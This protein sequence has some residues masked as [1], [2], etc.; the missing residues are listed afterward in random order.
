MVVG[1]S[2]T[3]GFEGRQRR[4]WRTMK[5]SRAS[6]PC[7]WCMA[8]DVCTAM[9]GIL[10]PT[11]IRG[12]RNDQVQKLLLINISWLTLGRAESYND[13]DCMIP[14]HWSSRKACSPHSKR[15]ACRLTNE[16]A[17]TGRVMTESGQGQGG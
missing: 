11:R 5:V 7:A 13:H 6:V 1:Q 4:A 9:T 16:G 17:T 8:T 15:S 10:S 2:P 12:K 14:L 3:P